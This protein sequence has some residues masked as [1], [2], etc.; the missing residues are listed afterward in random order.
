MLNKKNNFTTDRTARYNNY[1]LNGREDTYLEF[2]QFLKICLLITL[3]LYI[4][5]IKLNSN[6]IKRIADYIIKIISN[7]K[8][9]HQGFVTLKLINK[10]YEKKLNLPINLISRNNY[11]EAK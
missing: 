1:S 11:V 7:R 9:L 3:Y 6:F 4:F 5:G 10:Y 8:I 2:N